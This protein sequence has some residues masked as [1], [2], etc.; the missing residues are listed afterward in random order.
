MEIPADL[1]L[2][3]ANHQNST[4]AW[5]SLTVSAIVATA[6]ASLYY[7]LATGQRIGAGYS[8]YGGILT[9]FL[10]FRLLIGA[11]IAPPEV[12]SNYLDTFTLASTW[13]YAAFRIHCHFK[14]CCYGH[15]SFLPWSVVYF[16]E[17]GSITPLVGLP[18]HP[19]QLYS[20]LHGVL[21]GL[22]LAWL[23]PR[24]RAF[25]LQGRLHL[26]FLALLG[27]GRL[28]TDSFRADSGLQFAWGLSLNTLVSISLVLFGGT[29]LI[30]S[31][32]GSGSK[33]K[34]VQQA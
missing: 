32:L 1:P 19:A 27:G 21:L 34:G 3:R 9:Q 4:L 7:S 18:L 14:G 30:K 8:Y 20:S 17:S 5:G 33:I 26:L 24:R 23:Y 28:I 15:L 6:G 2:V 11:L 13:I 10:I 29:L 16:P 31:V 12:R 25:A 22:L